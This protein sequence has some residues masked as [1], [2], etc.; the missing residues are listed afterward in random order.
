MRKKRILVAPLDWG[1]GHA[2]RCIPIIQALIERNAEVILAADERPAQLLKKEFPELRHVR[3]PGYGMHYPVN[4]NM[5]WSMFRQLPKLFRGISEEHHMLARI[6]DEERIDAVISDNRWGAYSPKIPSIYVVTQLRVLMSSYLW[7]GQSIVDKANQRMIS[8]FNEIWIP[9]VDS[10]DNILGDL[11]PRSLAHERTYYI[12]TLSRMKRV[13][14]KKKQLDI[15]V[16]LSGLEPQRTVLE[17]LIIHQLKATTLRAVVVRGTPEVNES[18]DLTDTLTVVS[19]M[20]ADQLSNAI[21]S[22]H[23]VVARSGHS[24]IMDLSH[25]GT[26]AVFIPTPQQTEQEY[27]AR[28]LKAQRI[29]YSEPQESFSLTRAVDH[30]SSYTGFP[31]RKNDPAILHQR[32]DS[33]L[34]K[35]SL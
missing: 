1:L 19:A 26:N 7:W 14:P 2:T 18:I 9:D 15:L 17:E 21:A 3:Y 5:A 20:T 32:I 4:G 25:L 28:R 12:G 11:A 22:A 34:S 29:C 33:L 31:Q 27:L 6:I 16:I 23:L 30:A 8:Y 13:E 35:I 24:T 10:P